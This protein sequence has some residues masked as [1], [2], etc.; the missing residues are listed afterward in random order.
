M[1]EQFNTM[2]ENNMG[3][4]MS[5]RLTY[6]VILF[7]PTFRPI[8]IKPVKAETNKGSAPGIGTAEGGA[9]SAVTT[10]TKSAVA[11]PPSTTKN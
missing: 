1:T 4:L 7:T 8:T 3:R 9:M 5:V 10:P 2:A 6:A 11:L